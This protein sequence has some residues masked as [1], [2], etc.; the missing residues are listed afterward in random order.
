M[1]KVNVERAQISDWRRTRAVRLRALADLPDAFGSTLD[2]ELKFRD[3]DWRQ[4]LA[5]AD[6]AT[7]LASLDGADLGIVVAA[8]IDDGEAG[9]YAMWVAPEARGKGA[10]DELIKYAVA[11]ARAC[12]FRRISL[13]V[14]DFNTPAIRL[15]DRHGFRPT[16]E[17]GTLPPPR[18]H[19]T[20]HKRTLV[21]HPVS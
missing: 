8:R 12:G 18:T 15:Y 3:E 13:G 21:L 6:A 14:G 17:T 1:T 11:W 7:F 2:H 4:R 10:S 9:L 19:V 20:E 5:S 16:G